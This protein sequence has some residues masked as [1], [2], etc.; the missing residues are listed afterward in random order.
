MRRKSDISAS[1]WGGSSVPPEAVFFVGVRPLS[2][3]CRVVVVVGGCLGKQ[4]GEGGHG[5]TVGKPRRRSGRSFGEHDSLG[6]ER[7]W[8]CRVDSGGVSTPNCV[9]TMTMTMIDMCRWRGGHVDRR[10]PRDHQQRQ[11]R[12]GRLNTAQIRVTSNQYLSQYNS[13]YIL[14]VDNKGNGNLLN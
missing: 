1:S 2:G 11:V 6:R 10:Q 5:G 3:H 9:V 13:L 7:R 8:H 14:L 4:L 12:R